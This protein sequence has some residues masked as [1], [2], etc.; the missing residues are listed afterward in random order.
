MAQS[1][2]TRKRAVRRTRQHEV[3]LTRT[4]GD[5]APPGLNPSPEHKC[6]LGHIRGQEHGNQ[7]LKVSNSRPEGAGRAQTISLAQ[8][9]HVEAEDSCRKIPWGRWVT[10][11]IS[12]SPSNREIDGPC[13]QCSACF[14]IFGEQQ[15]T[16]CYHTEMPDVC[17][18]ICRRLH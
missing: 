2:C 9:L 5:P 11:L 13:L 15:I 8:A 6:F 16:L 4:E 17:P 3:K 10:W 18:L 1:S 12:L 7:L 14:Q